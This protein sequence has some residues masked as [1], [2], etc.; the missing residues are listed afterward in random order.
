MDKDLRSAVQRIQMLKNKMYAQC[1]AE[2]ESIV[3]NRITDESR[4]DTLFDQIFGFIEEDRFHDLYW[5]LINYVETY[6][7]ALGAFY[8]RMEEVHFE[9][10]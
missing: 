8:R 7:V 4:I 10:Y 5:K 2:Y 1:E 3:R 6:D 9:G